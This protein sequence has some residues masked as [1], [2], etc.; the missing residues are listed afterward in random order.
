MTALKHAEQ[1]GHEQVCV[2]LMEVG[3]EGGL[4]SLA[5]E[6]VEELRGEAARQ[7]AAVGKEQDTGICGCSGGDDQEEQQQ[8]PATP[9]VPPSQTAIR[10]VIHRSPE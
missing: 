1:Q 10:V 7:T 9:I 6:M 3:A 8:L 2:L 5:G 4:Q